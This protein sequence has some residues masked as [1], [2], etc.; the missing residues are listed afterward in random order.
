MQKRAFPVK[1]VP[2]SG[3]FLPQTPDQ[4]LCHW[5]RLGAKPPH[6]IEARAPAQAMHDRSVP[7]LLR[8]HFKHC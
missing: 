8:G 3:G 4:S 7:T 6:P 2:A 5:T 1:Y